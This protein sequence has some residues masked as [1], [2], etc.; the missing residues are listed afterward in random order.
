MGV[1]FTGAMHEDGLADT[2]DAMGGGRDATDILRIMRDSRIGTYGAIA[3]IIVFAL[4]GAF[5]LDMR[6]S[7]WVPA[8]VCAH[9]CARLSCVL[10]VLALPY[11]RTD[12]PGLA[13]LLAQGGKP[14]HAVLALAVAAI[15]CVLTA[16]MAGLYALAA[17][18][19]ATAIAGASFRSRIGGITGDC[20]GA[21][22]IASELSALLI[23]A[24]SLDGHLLMIL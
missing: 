7:A 8:L 15:I 9:A 11:A 23:L 17:S 12:G 2:A 5:L 1:L 13:A 4:R 16:G 10:L 3:L 24:P 18:L 20:L 22:A 6:P 14:V 21:A 19:L